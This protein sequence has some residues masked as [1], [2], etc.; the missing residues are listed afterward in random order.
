[1][2][3]WDTAPSTSSGTKK[4]SKIQEIEIMAAKNSWK[5]G[6]LQSQ[7]SDRAVKGKC[8]SVRLASEKVNWNSHNPAKSAAQTVK[9]YREWVRTRSH[10]TANLHFHL[11]SLLF[12]LVGF[13][14]ALNLFKAYLL[15]SV[16]KQNRSNEFLFFLHICFLICFLPELKFKNICE[17]VHESFCHL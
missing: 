16:Q 14:S 12:G 4:V 5:A 7:R 10:S 9:F 3:Y 2:G 15:C 11:W 17:E 1:M 8:Q 6:E 13:E